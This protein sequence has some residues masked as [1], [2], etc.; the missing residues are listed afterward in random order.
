MEI[1]L[2]RWSMEFFS[3]TIIYGFKGIMAIFNLQV[4]IWEFSVC[5]KY[6][7]QVISHKV[8]CISHVQESNYLTLH[9]ES[10]AWTLFPFEGCFVH[11][12]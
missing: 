11:A 4:C 6:L 9:F 7:L 12:I 2:L 3:I 10:C 5:D 1:L 8:S